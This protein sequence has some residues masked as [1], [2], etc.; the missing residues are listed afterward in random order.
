MAR[1][2][3][4]LVWVVVPAPSAG[5][6]E[7]GGCAPVTARRRR[8]RRSWVERG[9]DRGAACSTV[10]VSPMGGREHACLWWCV[11]RVDGHHDPSARLQPG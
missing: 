7:D 3:G 8:Q 1:C 2:A 5:G 9:M 10:M 6:H 4:R 11:C